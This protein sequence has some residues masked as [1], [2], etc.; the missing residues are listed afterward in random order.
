MFP[1]LPHLLSP[2]MVWSVYP[3][4]LWEVCFLFRIP[5]LVWDCFVHFRIACNV[6]EV[7]CPKE[8]SVRLENNSSSPRTNIPRL[9]ILIVTN[10]GLMYLSNNFVGI[11]YSF[12]IHYLV[13]ECFVH[14]RISSNVYDVFCPWEIS[15]RPGNNSSRP[16][17]NVLKLTILV[18]T[19]NGLMYLSNNFMGIM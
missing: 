7:F 1:G 15:V 19:N 10:N 2:P 3:I 11:M 13:W 12:R 6:Y 14:F 8:K 9:T 18:V 5:Y 17:T 16:R 4:T